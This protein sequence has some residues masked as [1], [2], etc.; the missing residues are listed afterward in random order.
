[1]CSKHLSVG[2]W[3][4]IIILGAFLAL[5][6]FLSCSTA[7]AQDVHP[8]VGVRVHVSPSRVHKGTG[9]FV[10]KTHVLTAYHILEDHLKDAAILITT[11]KGTSVE[12]KLIA[13]SK[14]RDLALLEAQGPT[15]T[16][17]S[18]CNDYDVGDKVYLLTYEKGKLISKTGKIKRI[19]DTIISH[20]VRSNIPTK[21][22]Y[23]GAPVLKQTAKAVCLVG[24]HRLAGS[25]HIPGY[26]AYEFAKEALSKK[27]K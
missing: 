24:V 22:G 18:F 17:L 19:K 21:M 1:M 26:I 14:I 7:E 2:F 5:V 27:P 11:S 16:G 15:S 6:V 25:I 12:A 8:V 10:T 23:S 3:S 20:Y 9:F 13:F 4:S